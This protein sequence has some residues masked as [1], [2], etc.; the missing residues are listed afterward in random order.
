MAAMTSC[1]NALYLA[2]VLSYPRKTIN[3]RQHNS[4]SCLYGKETPVLGIL[5]S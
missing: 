1:E 3:F 4:V 5:D 2:Q